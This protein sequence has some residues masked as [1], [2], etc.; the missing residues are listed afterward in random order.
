MLRE[1]PRRANLRT[2]ALE[3]K[4]MKSSTLKQ[5]PSLLTP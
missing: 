1:L 3:P 2:L 4:W 5:L